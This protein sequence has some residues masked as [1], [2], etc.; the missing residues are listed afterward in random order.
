MLHLIGGEQVVIAGG[1]QAAYL[2]GQSQMAEEEAESAGTHDKQAPD[3]RSLRRTD[4]N[5]V[6][7]GFFAKN[8]K[9]GFPPAEMKR[10]RER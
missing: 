8:P 9:R 4:A 1:A 5:G 7:L 6:R 3:R 2:L 10:R